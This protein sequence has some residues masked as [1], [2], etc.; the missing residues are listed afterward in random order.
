[1]RDE[2]A[3]LYEDDMGVEWQETADPRRDARTEA[4]SERTHMIEMLAERDDA[5]M[6]DYLEGE[7]RWSV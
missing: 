3:Y 1:M 7:R 6:M 4:D 5:L 2:V